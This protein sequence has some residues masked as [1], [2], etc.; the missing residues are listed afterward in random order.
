MSRAL[1][2]LVVLLVGCGE[3][4]R[5]VHVRDARALYEIDRGDVTGRLLVDA[6]DVASCTRPWWLPEVVCAVDATVTL[7]GPLRLE[8]ALDIGSAAIDVDLRSLPE[9]RHLVRLDTRAPLSAATVVFEV[10]VEPWVP[11]DAAIG[12]SIVIAIGLAYV[13][14]LVFRG[15]FISNDDARPKG[16]AITLA[17]V[18]TVIAQATIIP[19]A[20]GGEKAEPLLLAIPTL[21][22]AFAATTTIID[23]IAKR[24]LGSHRGALLLSS[25]A[26]AATMPLIVAATTLSLP[27]VIALVVVMALVAFF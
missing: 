18:I 26:A 20:A 3:R 12:L 23:A 25:V 11:L 4:S 1:V 7:T 15:R 22:G 5:T 17:R 27:Y 14:F 24:R 8:L 6:A 19:V 16:L 2:I 21:L 9:G 10:R 13:S